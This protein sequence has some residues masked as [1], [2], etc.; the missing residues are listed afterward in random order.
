MRSSATAASDPLRTSRT[1]AML[2]EMREIII[3]CRG[4]T[5]PDELW[6]RYLDAA[7][8]EGA[9]IFGR[10]LDAFWDAVEHSG[11]GW[12]GKVRLIFEASAHLEPLRIRRGDHSFLDALKNIANDASEVRITFE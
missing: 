4:V 1:A 12:P 5:T 10:N 7:K 3:N 2:A 6:Q 11:P 9:E 8:P